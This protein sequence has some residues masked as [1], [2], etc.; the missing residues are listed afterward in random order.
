MYSS[1]P[2]R[3]TRTNKIFTWKKGIA[4]FGKVCL[5]IYALLTLYPLYWLFISA[6]KTNQ[7]F[8]GRPFSLPSSW[9][10][11]N[12]TRAWKVSGMGTA[13]INSVIVTF[14]ALFLMLLFG[15]IAAYILSK[16]EFSLKA[17]IMGLFL[18][19]MLIPIHSTLVPLFIMM[20]KIHLLD[21]YMSLILPYTS[22]QLPICIFVIG[23]YLTSVPKEVEEAALIDG[24]GYWGVFTRIMMPLAKPA[25]ATVGILGFLQF[26]NDFAFPLVFINNQALKTLPLSLSVFA[27]GY[28]TDYALTTAAMAIAVIP[29]IV[30][31]LF[32]QEQ[33]M[34]G[35]VAGAVKG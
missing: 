2:V 4:G 18:L 29:T 35:M 13:M 10:F 14:S 9:H 3:V 34:K 25:M 28:G 24:C 33:I 6:F 7:E 32:F 19:G 22:F 17:P 27:T 23:A 31:Y 1:I 12:F 11:D 8:F 30:I 26:W 21:T 15:T 5:F 20:R 16:F